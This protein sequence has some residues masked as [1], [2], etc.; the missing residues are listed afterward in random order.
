MSNMHPIAQAVLATVFTFLGCLGINY[1]IAYT[2]GAE[3]NP[4]WIVL[5]V[6]SL[7][8]GACFYFMNPRR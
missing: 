3:F 4:N 6:I 2:R 5:V 8:T 7:V 1:V